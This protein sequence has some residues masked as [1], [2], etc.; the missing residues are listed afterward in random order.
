MKRKRST[1]IFHAKSVEKKEWN[2]DFNS[3]LPLTL[4]LIKIFQKTFIL[5]AN[6]AGWTSAM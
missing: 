6:E 1:L 3:Q 4:K 5:I 2:F